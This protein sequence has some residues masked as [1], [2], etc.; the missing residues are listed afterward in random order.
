M[1]PLEAFEGILGK[2]VASIEPFATEE[3]EPDPLAETWEELTSARETT[4]TDVG[5]FTAEA[6][7][8]ATNWNGSENSEPVNNGKLHTAR[9]SLHAIAERCRKLSR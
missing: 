6:T 3:R 4:S 7:T 5:A 8:C 9:E 2:L 1:K